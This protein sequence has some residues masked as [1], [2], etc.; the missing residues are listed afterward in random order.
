MDGFF[1][2][3]NVIVLE[4]VVVL[5]KVEDKE[6]VLKWLGLYCV[7]IMSIEEIC[8]LIFKNEDIFFDGVV[9]L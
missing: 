9:I 1:C 2:G 3:Y 5:V 6:W 7:K 8:N 4:D